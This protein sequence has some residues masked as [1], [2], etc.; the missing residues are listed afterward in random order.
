MFLRAVFSGTLHTL[1]LLTL[2]VWCLSAPEHN[3]A[4][5]PTAIVPPSFNIL[6]HCRKPNVVKLKGSLKHSSRVANR[7][8]I[9]VLQAGK[10]VKPVKPALVQ[11]PL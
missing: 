11:L 10:L 5:A 2:L 7:L 8:V 4:K 9:Q 1:D 6:T 3:S